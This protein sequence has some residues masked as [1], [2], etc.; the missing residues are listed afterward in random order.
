MTGEVKVGR[1]VL[2]PPRRARSARPTNQDG[3]ITISGIFSVPFRPAQASVAG[4]VWIIALLCMGLTG[5]AGY[6]RG[7]IRAAFTLLGLVFGLLLA[8]PLSPLTGLL[9]PVLG[10]QHP[11]WQLFVPPAFAFLAVLIL[12]KIVGNV[13]NEKI[14][15]HISQQKNEHLL[16]RWERICTRLGFCVGV[17]NG[18]VYFFILMLPVYLAGYFAAE[19]PGAPAGLSLLATLRAQLHEC[20]LDRVLAAHDPI[21][22]EIYQASDL[23][24]LVLRNPLLESRLAHYPPFLAYSQSKEMQDISS[25]TALQEM[26]QT[27]AKIGDILN[28]PKIKALVTNAVFPEQMH[29]LLG[30]DL[31]DLQEFLTT[32]KSPQFDSEKILGIWDIDVAVTMAGERRQHPDM[33][34]SQISTMRA[35]LIPMITGLSLMTT[36]DNQFILRKQNPNSA[37]SSP[38]GQGTWK[39]TDD[40]Y[41]INLPGNKPNPVPVAPTADGT[42]QLRRDSRLLVFNKEM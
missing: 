40:G 13:L 38:V 23:V 9:L 25:D 8:R 30:G 26:I 17:P 28:H 37:Q 5:L 7:P 3:R 18:V 31:T 10:L 15:I 24:A 20:R 39:K 21:P 14:A 34:R 4:M 42:L 1:A 29:R 27:Q 6:N 22:P 32:G 11:A 33:T 12:F 41:E 2:C 36:P 16:F 35:T 19:A